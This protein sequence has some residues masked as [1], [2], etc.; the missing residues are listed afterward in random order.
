M[1][2]SKVMMQKKK[3][4]VQMYREVLKTESQVYYLFS[5]LKWA[6]PGLFYRLFSV[7]LKSFIQQIYVKNVHPVYGT[8]IQTYDPRNMSLL[9]P[10][11][12]LRQQRKCQKQLQLPDDSS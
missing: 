7:F 4:N 12:R 11:Y 1:D 9:Q 3:I 10:L 2:D 5:L 6:N 8:G